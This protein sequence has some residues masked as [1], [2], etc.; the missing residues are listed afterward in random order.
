MRYKWKPSKAQ[1]KEFAKKMEDED[2][3]M[4]YE[5]RKGAKAEKRR[6]ES[7]F[8]YPTAG[9]VYVPTETQYRT[10]FEYI[11]IGSVEQQDA[12][13]KVVAGYLFNTKVH[14]DTIHI[15]NEI[16]RNK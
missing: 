11:D 16:Q 5:A 6:S 15:V 9:G 7:I 4:E 2:F 12:C 1:R 8:E 13:N 10:A 14:H 3:K